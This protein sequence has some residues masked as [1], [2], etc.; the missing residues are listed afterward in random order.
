MLRS[1][2]LARSL[3]ALA[4][5][6]SL[7]ACGGGAPAG[8]DGAAAT[9]AV[10]VSGAQTVSFDETGGCGKSLGDDASWGGMFTSPDSAWLLDITVEGTFDGGT[11]TTADHQPGL[12]RCS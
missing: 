6:A 3:A 8:S 12:A 7:A 2:S 5:I 10:G 4:L 9:M 1:R 11:Y